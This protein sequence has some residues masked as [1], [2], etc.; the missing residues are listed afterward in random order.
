MLPRPF[1][2]CVTNTIGI[3]DNAA[4]R[5]AGDWVNLATQ[6]PLFTHSTADST[7]DT[8]MPSR[9]ERRITWRAAS[10]F[11]TLSNGAD[12][13]SRDWDAMETLSHSYVVCGVCVRVGVSGKEGAFGPKAVY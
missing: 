11:S 1:S 12:R 4:S 5:T 8:R 13:A 2:S 10:F 9:M 6:A 3:M 7:P